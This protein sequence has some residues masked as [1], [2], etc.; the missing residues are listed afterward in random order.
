LASRGV[1]E[2]I[3]SITFTDAQYKVLQALS[4]PE[5][6][7]EAYV[8]AL[9]GIHS[10]KG[11]KRLSI[12]KQETCFIDKVVPGAMGD[13]VVL[14]DELVTEARRKNQAIAVMRKSPTSEGNF[15][16]KDD[17]FDN[18]IFS[19][20]RPKT[21]TEQLIVSLKMLTDGRVLGRH[22]KENGVFAPIY[23]VKHIGDD[24][25]IWY[26]DDGTEGVPEHSIRDVQ[27]FGRGTYAVLK[28]LKVG[29]AGISGTGAVMTDLLARHSVGSL[30]LADPEVVEEKNLNR[31]PYTTME[32]VRQKRPKVDVLED[33]IKKLEFGT[34]VITFK[35]D[36]AHLEVVHEFADCDVLIGCMDS[37][38]GRQLLNRIA[39][40]YSIPYFDIGVGLAADGEGGI[41]YICGNIHYLQPGRSSLITRGLYTY[42]QVL[43]A[44]LK[45]K[46]PEL[47]EKQLKEGYIQG[48]DEDRPAVMAVNSF[49]SALGVL[50]FL[51][52]IHPYKIRSNEE[53][54]QY[55][56][57]ISQA[58]GL[59]Y[60]EDKFKEDTNFRRYAG[61]GDMFPLLDM[62]EFG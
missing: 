30:V 4:E 45:R 8:L 25:Q 39:T 1:A 29:I 15:T 54:A 20:L 41:D 21:E 36:I 34:E 32:D 31:I 10:W 58:R 18:L 50:E 51:S 59:I 12:H 60:R 55:T 13:I 5:V 61:R 49:Y 37:I 22:I 2:M 42:E 62:A 44:N 19:Y 23:S 38:D 33:A 27:L 40:F 46:Q 16:N 24:I 9:C 14:L 43:A 47:Y 11:K 57:S 6:E 48:I 52:R 26:S 3:K 7:Q 17:D 28:K 53:F 56:Y 35:Q